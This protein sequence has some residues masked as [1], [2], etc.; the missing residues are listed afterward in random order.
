M[1]SAYPQRVR[2]PRR[3]QEESL[4]QQICRYLRLQYP[5]VIFRSDFASGLRLSM[6]QAT[7]NK[8]LQSS[9]SFPDLQILYPSRGY[10]GLLLELKRPGT[11]IYLTRGERKGELTADPHI[12]EQALMITELLKLGYFARFAVG[13]DNCKKLIDWYLNENYTAPPD[14]LELF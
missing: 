4:Q 10:H 5:N 1:Q 11:T 2:R 3:K 9:R 13:F 6:Y 8:N 14:T 7:K 12:Q